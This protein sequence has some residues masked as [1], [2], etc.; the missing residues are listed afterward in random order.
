MAV[1]PQLRPRPSYQVYMLCLIH[2][3]NEWNQII[4]AQQQASTGYYIENVIVPKMGV[5][6][7]F[8]LFHTS[9]PNGFSAITDQIT[10]CGTPTK[11]QTLLPS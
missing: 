2:T 4:L 1:A 3:M 10:S 6:E 5:V 11:T 8:Y 7:T 9:I